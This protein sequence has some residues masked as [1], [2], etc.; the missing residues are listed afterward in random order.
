MSKKMINTFYFLIILL[1]A[2]CTGETKPP[3]SSTQEIQQLLNNYAGIHQELVYLKVI[4]YENG[5]I[6]IDII[7]ADKELAKML[8]EKIPLHS[9][10]DDRLSKDLRAIDRSLR[11]HQGVTDVVFT[12]SCLEV[13]KK[14]GA[15]ENY[16]EK[17]SDQEKEKFYQELMQKYPD[18]LTMPYRIMALIAGERNAATLQENY[19][20]KALEVNPNQVEIINELCWLY[21]TQGSNLQWAKEKMEQVLT[22]FPGYAH[23]YNTYAAILIKMGDPVKAITALEKGIQSRGRQDDE[24]KASD[25]YFL[26]ISYAGSG[27]MTA[28]REALDKAIKLNP[29]DNFREEAEKAVR[30]N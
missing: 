5:V 20:K 24:Y 29:N 8:M 25:H 11:Q 6:T 9:I 17:V 12:A 13:Y 23:G 1:M 27:N 18:S 26:A 21:Y 30:Q 28:A 14:W 19:L 16:L 3:V 7:D 22:L 15:K 4:K 2:G 10:G